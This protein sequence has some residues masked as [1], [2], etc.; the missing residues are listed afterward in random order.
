[1]IN[2][3]PAAIMLGDQAQH[4][5]HGALFSDVIIQYAGILEQRQ[6]IV[7]G[8]CKLWTS[9][10]N[11][12]VGCELSCAQSLDLGETGAEQAS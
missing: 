4:A 7:T 1:M 3:T 2:R 12:T 10:T 6:K 9:V 8:L 11:I 5:T